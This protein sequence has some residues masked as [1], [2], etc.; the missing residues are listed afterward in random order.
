MYK[1]NSRS[2]SS[3]CWGAN[4]KYISIRVNANES[5]TVYLDLIKII[6]CSK[7]AKTLLQGKKMIRSLFKELK[8]MLDACFLIKRDQVKCKIELWPFNGQKGLWLFRMINKF[9]KFDDYFWDTL[10]QTLQIKDLRGNLEPI[11]HMDMLSLSL[12]T[13]PPPKPK[14][15]KRKMKIE[16]IYW[17]T[18]RRKILHMPGYWK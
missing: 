17:I 4:D 15:K 12:K 14:E 13:N 10:S 16:K 11:F 5:E 6:T 2:L 7:K 1:R 18:N 9:L 8:T 3:L